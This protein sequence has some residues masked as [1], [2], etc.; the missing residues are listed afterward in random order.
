MTIGEEQKIRRLQWRKKAFPEYDSTFENLSKEEHRDACSSVFCFC[1]ESVEKCLPGLLLAECRRVLIEKNPY[2]NRFSRI[3][4]E[5]LLYG[6]SSL[7]NNEFL[8]FTKDRL[9]ILYTWLRLVAVPLYG[10]GNI[11]EINAAKEAVR[12]AILQKSDLMKG[13]ARSKKGDGNPK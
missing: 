7:P 10:R 8:C 11:E 3:S 6:M 12:F 5:G 9:R 4:G 2:D 1:F 13:N